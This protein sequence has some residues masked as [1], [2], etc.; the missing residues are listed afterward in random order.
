MSAAVNTYQKVSSY[1]GRKG[2][3]KKVVLLFSGGLDTSVMLKWIQDEYQAQVIALTVD[4]GQ[5][6]DDLEAIRKKALKLGAIKAMVVDAKKEFAYHYLAKGI[7][8][9]AHYQGRYYLSTPMGRPLLAKLAVDVARAEGADTIAHGSTGKGNDQVR[10]EG[11]VLTLAPEMK[12]IAPVREWSLGR[13]E[14][15]E[16]ARINHI[17]V[18]QT[19]DSPYSWDDNMWGVTGESGE[20]EN[21]A[22]IPPLEKILQVCKTPEKA[23]RTPEYIKLR[24]VKGIPVELNGK[25]MNLVDI[26][27]KLNKI[28]AQHAVGIAHHIE[29]RLVGLKVRGLYEAPGAEIII[30]AHFNLEKY[31]CTREENQFKAEVDTKWAYLCYGALWFEPLMDDLNA[32]TDKINE[33]VSGLVTVKVY[34]G[35]TE[36]VA[37]D[38]ANSIFDEKLAT[39]MKSSAFNQNASAGFI[40]IYT[41]QMRLAQGKER[42]ALLTIGEDSN[43]KKFLPLVERLSKLGFHF[44]ATEHTHEF[45]AKHKIQSVMLHKM[46]QN[47]YP[48]L[49]DVLRQNVF[50]LIINVPYKNHSKDAKKDE[51]VIK[52]WAVNNDVTLVSDFATAERLVAKL[53]KRLIVRAKKA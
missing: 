47:E 53:E 41:L 4:I 48:N 3:V 25:P 22:L 29:D 18:K 52:K 33:K 23:K 10:I 1:E 34:K 42:F 49:E 7:K 21:P 14:E 11:S 38:T 6:A 17:P 15:L 9:N 45:L 24:F 16:Y 44:Y 36:V 46:Y 32:F 37:V 27:M 8:A 31:V 30:T 50:D 5:Q 20:I 26:I 40:E 13:D 19:V 51:K 28:G 43:K 12:I 2:E 35:L 39:F